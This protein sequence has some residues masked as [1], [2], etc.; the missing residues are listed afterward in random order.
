MYIIAITPT[1][2]FTADVTTL[3][4]YNS[5]GK[6]VTKGFLRIMAAM[7]NKNIVALE[8]V[9][10]NGNVLSSWCSKKCRMFA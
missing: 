3:T 10:Y 9:D 2:T 6:P 5:Q 8:R 4:L 7:W 1:E